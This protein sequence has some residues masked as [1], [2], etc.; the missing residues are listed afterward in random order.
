M[1]QGQIDL[2]L[3]TIH[4]SQ[5]EY[6]ELLLK[7]NLLEYHKGEET[8][9][10]LVELARSGDG[11]DKAE[12]TFTKGNLFG[13]NPYSDDQLRNQTFIA[14]ESVMNRIDNDIN[15]ILSEGYREGKGIAKVRD[16]ITKTFNQ[17]KGYESER[18][19][20]TEIHHAQNM[21]IMQG[22]TD[23]GVE[24]TQWNSAHDSRVRG[25][26]KRDKANHV[27]L[28]GEIIPMGGTYSN[29]LSFPG[30][31]TGPIYEWVNCRCGNLPFI[32]PY[33]K[34]APPG[35]AQF[36]EKDL[37]KIKVEPLPT[38]KPVTPKPTSKPTSKPKPVTSKPKPKAKPKTTTTTAPK[39]TVPKKSKLTKEELTKLSFEELAAH[40]EIEYQGI[41]KYDYDGKKYH[42]FK[43][44]FPDGRDFIFRFEEGAVKSYTK[45]GIAHPNEIIHEVFK[46]PEILRNETREIWFKNNNSGVIHK[47][48]KSGYD[49]F[50]AVTG[51][52]NSYVKMTSRSLQQYE[53]FNHRIVINPKYFKGGGRGRYAFLWEQDPKEITSWKKTIH[54]ELTHSADLTQK[55]WKKQKF[56]RAS[57]S[58]EYL[59]I[60]K[61]EPSFTWYANK[62][63]TESFAEH[64]GYIS[65]MEANPSEQDKLIP[66]KVKEDGKTVTKHINYK[67]YKK[68]Y[69]KHHKYFT[70]LFKG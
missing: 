29:G 10:R 45:K 21:G 15:N 64:G 27:I 31:K 56:E 48:T 47:F 51:G 30:D 7:H 39:L 54:H 14:S 35:M 24:Y 66:V 6:Y 40:H 61:A 55:T 69:P 62:E 65:Y 4:E 63:Y 50:D 36:K 57:Y 38:T 70:K 33:D 23:M 13:T 28:D 44:T 53:D 2:I 8:A 26:R 11:A 3:A 19:A 43:E 52:Y 60:E 49:S 5:M 25:V 20:R 16:D 34:M 37:I 46:A 18:I 58:D 67:Q 41:Q 1:F 59:E 17:L 42:V 9:K 22:Y 12:A 68:M 32:M